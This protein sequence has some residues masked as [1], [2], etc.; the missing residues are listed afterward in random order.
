MT[1]GINH[2]GHA[3]LT[4]LLMP[5]LKKVKCFRVIFVSSN[6]HLHIKD[7]SNFDLEDIDFKQTNYDLWNAYCR[8]KSANILFA[9]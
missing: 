7:S 8:S 4:H 3:Y 5:K 6:A 9:S 2:F 1:M